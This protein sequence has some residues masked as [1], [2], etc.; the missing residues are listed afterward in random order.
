[1]PLRGVVA[2][3]DAGV[4]GV[5]VFVAALALAGCG[6]VPS[7]Q[8][9]EP[10]TPPATAS[11]APSGPPVAA[12]AVTPRGELDGPFPVTK[13][14]DGDTIWVRIGGDRVKVRLI[15][16]DTAETV[17]P[18]EPVGC[19]GPEASEQAQRLLAGTSVYLERDP[20][21]GDYDAYDRVL[22][23]V[24]L[25][26]GRLFN[27]EMIRDGYAIEYTY[28]DPYAYQAEFR[29]A[30]SEAEGT[31]AGMWSPRTCGGAVAF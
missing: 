12:G 18:G 20:T 8:S 10:A 17:A 19:F 11:M 22:A 23:Y 13:V 9:T 15:G 6:G 4:R 1:M 24:W 30:Q 16:I 2:A 7:V 5:G 31:Q 27:L 14:V 3:R 28:D 29:A 25:E 21:Q 26:D